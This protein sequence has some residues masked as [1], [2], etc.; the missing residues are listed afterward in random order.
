MHKQFSHTRK[1]FLQLFFVWLV[2]VSM[3]L[4]DVR[5]TY[6]LLW[7]YLWNCIFVFIHLHTFFLKCFAIFFI[8]ICDFLAIFCPKNRSNEI[9]IRIRRELPVYLSATFGPNISDFFDF[10]LNWGSIFISHWWIAPS[11]IIGTHF[12]LRSGV[13]YSFETFATALWI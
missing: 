10:C 6:I 12:D 4:K 9:R 8:A 5:L 2:V 7:N 1:V 13:Y 11:E 3:T